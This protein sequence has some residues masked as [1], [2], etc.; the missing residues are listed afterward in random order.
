MSATSEVAHELATRDRSQQ[1][2]MLLDVAVKD[3][4]K[5][6]RQGLGVSAAD[7]RIMRA[8]VAADR[9]LGRAPR[10]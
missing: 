2:D 5:Y 3:A 10:V 6:L 9:I 4:V 8:G 1:A 7:A